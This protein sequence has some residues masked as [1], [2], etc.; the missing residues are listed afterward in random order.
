ML[1]TVGAVLT[2]LLFTCKPFTALRPWMDEL[3]F[4]RGC[5]RAAWL[6]GIFLLGF[7]RMGS[8]F[9]EWEK[10][11]ERLPE[12]GAPIGPAGLTGQ[13]ADIREKGG[14]Q[15]ILLKTETMAQVLVYIEKEEADRQ[16]GEKE[17][18]G[19]LQ[20]GEKEATGQ[21]QAGEKE[22]AAQLRI[23]EQVTLWGEVSRFTEARNPGQFDLEAYYRSRRIS[24]A[25]FADR[26][27][28][29][30]GTGEKGAAF[31]PYLDGLYRFRCRCSRVLTAI[32]E[33]ED[34][35]IFRAA[36][37]GEK[38]EMDE[39]VKDLYQRSGI[40]HLL[41]ISGLHLSMLG[42]GLYKLLREAGAGYGASALAGGAA[43][44]SY[45][46]MT[47]ASGSALRAA[48]MLTAAFLAAY[49]G[50]TYDL[51]SAL[52]LAAL[53]LAFSR[54]FLI[55][56][57]GFQLSF[58]AVLGIGLLGAELEKAMDLKKG[59]QKN[60]LVSLSVQLM[61][62][63]VVLWHYFQYPAYGICLNLLVVPLMGYVIGSGLLG[64]GAGFFAPALGVAA[65][66]S[67]HYILQGYQKL[68]R[69]F[70]ALPG[71]EVVLGRPGWGQIAAYYLLL[72]GMVL[73]LRGA[74]AKRGLLSIPVR[75][76][77]RKLLFLAAGS[78]CCFLVLRPPVQK[79]C[80]VTFLDVGQGDGIVIVSEGDTFKS[81][82]LESLETAKAGDR[83]AG[84]AEPTGA[85]SV[86]A[87]AVE[88]VGG[89]H[90]GQSVL[91]VDGGSTSEKRLGEDRLEPFLKSKGIRCI[92]GALVSHG[93][94]DHISGLRYL[95]EECGQ[96]QIR[97]LILPEKG[98]RD[99]AYAPLLAAAK[100]R[101]TIVCYMDAGDWI[102]AGDTRLVCLYPEK[103]EVIDE[104]DRNQQSLILR[105]DYE[106]AHMLLTGDADQQGERR[107]VERQTGSGRPVD[108]E[109]Q[110]DPGDRPDDRG[111]AAV[112]LSAIQVLKASHHG[113][114]YSNS[115][116]LLE[117][118]RPALTVISYGEGNRYGHPH[119]EALE[120]I[121]GAGSLVLK[122]GE[123]GAVMLHI[124]DGE[125]R[126]STYLP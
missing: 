13:V 24:M 12:D 87:G 20:A 43:V 104:T 110:A 52:S 92:D 18:T 38:E 46:L 91:L 2:V 73:A 77:C 69:L 121:C 63:P 40:S 33:E 80:S 94:E 7:F 98:R 62:A 8:A 29:A 103:E 11:R 54:P 96:I 101:G 4:R 79:G 6:M 112:P 111:P 1:L 107:M 86:E 42:M 9:E 17:A 82:G 3:L 74:W 10:V 5:L 126:Y 105:V 81:A 28:R 89:R 75:T 44:I 117:A 37:L 21:L 64:I 61:T 83:K 113:S 102:Q 19:Q 26:L 115:Q 84:S 56:D 99:E 114:R 100:A 67:G 122:T 93:D 108:V 27:E 78:L 22:A 72:A 66:G 41:A 109:G 70:L 32:C 120:R 31:S 45:G 59:W 90:T 57:S 35:Q 65:V 23:G 123:Q 58:G 76:G 95:L 47:G 125:L 34:S 14:Y 36:I 88:P 53:L 55:G 25:L 51:L 30:E 85:G 16:A 49:L 39:A 71:S 124:Q 97:R 118:V 50:R 116:E 15:K 48:I 106:G 60:L 68:C 119:E